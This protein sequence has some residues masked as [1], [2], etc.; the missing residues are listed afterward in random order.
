M[1]DFF[2][3]KEIEIPDDVAKILQSDEQILL[4]A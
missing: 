1:M 3:G 4:A 2:T